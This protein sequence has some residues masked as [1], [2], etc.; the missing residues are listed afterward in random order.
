MRSF[1]RLVSIHRRATL[2]LVVAVAA[3]VASSVAL[4][5]N[6]L[7]QDAAELL[8]EQ[9]LDCQDAGVFT[10]AQG[11]PLNRY[12]GSW[13]S[14]VDPSFIRFA[15]PAN[16]ILPGNNTKCSPLVTHLLKSTYNWNWKDYTFIDPLTLT[17]K[18]SA[19]PTPFQYVAL[20]KQQRGF[21]EIAT[22]D[23]ARP[24]DVL[25]W[26]QVGSTSSDHTMLIANIDWN[27]GKPYPLGYPN[28]NP[29]L[30][31]TTY[32]EVRVID[33]SSSTHTA[34]TRMVDVNGTVTQIAG[35]GAGT[36][37]VLV[38]EDY[39]IV[40][41]TWSLPT[42]NYST[43]TNTWVGSLNTRLKLTPTWEIAIGRIVVNH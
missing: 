3:T 1:T 21:T 12:G 42:S 5:Q 25:S 33:S 8:L 28:S 6:P 19:S 17:S 32:F 41:T 2:V 27:S 23:T 22:L 34:D 11:T 9:I 29:A 15:D 26:W 39:R 14:N 31:G 13:N 18:S 43:Q 20:I 16:G 36:I 37:G 38:D 40:G 7:H 30:A 4:A 35:I 10:D 24:G